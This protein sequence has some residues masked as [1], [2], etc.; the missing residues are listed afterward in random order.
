[1][2][3]NFRGLSPDELL[4]RGMHSAHFSS[5][6]HLG[7]TPPTV[8]EMATAVAKRE[9]TRKARDTMGPKAKLAIHGDVTGVTVT[10]ITAPAA[11]PPPAQPV[12]TASSAPIL[13]GPSTK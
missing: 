12:S 11:A 9:A 6:T 7:W 1:M 10:P 8:E 2:P 13:L 3:T 5:A 4:A